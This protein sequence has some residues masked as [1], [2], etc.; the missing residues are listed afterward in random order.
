MDK[1]FHPVLYNGRNY[2]YMSRLKL[3]H[4]SKRAHGQPVYYFV[5]QLTVAW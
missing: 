3:I 4:A 5:Y 2:L 1:L